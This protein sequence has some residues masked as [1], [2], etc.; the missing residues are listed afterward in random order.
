MQKRPF[1]FG[2]AAACCCVSLLVGGVVAYAAS[3]TPEIDRANA[4]IQLSGKLKAA[5]C[6]GEDQISYVT[7]SGSWKGAETQVLP[8][9]TDYP[10]TG[11]V[12]VTGIQWTINASTLR[13]VLTGTIKMSAA[14]PV[15]ATP[16]YSGKLTLI[17]QGMPVA[18]ATVAARGWIVAGIVLPDEGVTPGDDSLVANVEFAITPGGANGEFGDLPPQLGFPAFSVVTNVAPKA[19]D[20]TC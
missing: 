12:T 11:P 8:D 16:V 1:K 15:G 9:P 4:N 19:L 5:G 3:G 17:T 20:G 14:T 10:L 2:V 6:V 18:G 7:W 13:G